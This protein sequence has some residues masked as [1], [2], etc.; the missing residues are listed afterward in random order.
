MPN[1]PIRNTAAYR[2]TA[3]SGLSLNKVAR[4]VHVGV[5]I[6][7]S[8]TPAQKNGSDT[9]GGP[10]QRGALN[11]SPGGGGGGRFQA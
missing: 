9:T 8:Q 2:R 5:L 7:A 1:S 11:P 3:T 10:S 6:S 4:S